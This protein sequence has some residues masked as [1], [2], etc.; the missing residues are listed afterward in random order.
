MQKGSLNSGGLILRRADR[1]AEGMTVRIKVW[2]HPRPVI[3]QVARAER[4]FRDNRYI[5][6]EFFK[7]DADK[8]EHKIGFLLYADDLVEIVL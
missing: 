6:V 7:T 3:R 8:F 4:T 5:D 2:E 1:L